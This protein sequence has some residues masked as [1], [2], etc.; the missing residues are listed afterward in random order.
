MKL[1]IV[2]PCYNEGL[3]LN[4][5]YSSLSSALKD[6]KIS[7]ELIMVDDGS[8][9]DTYK[10]LL[11]LNKL[12]KNVKVISFSKNFGKEQA[13]YAGLLDAT[14]NYTAIMD[15]DLQHTPTTLIEMYYKLI[16]N[17]DYD[18]VCAYRANRDDESTLKRTLTSL[19]YKLNNKISDVKLLPGAG[20]FRVFTKE[21]REA[22]ISFKEKTRFSKGIFSWIGFNTIYVPY[23][24]EKRTYG[25]SKWSIFKLIKYSLGGIISFSTVPVKSI[26]VL[27]SLLF[28]ISL[29]DFILMGHLSYRTIILFIGFVMFFI[30]IIALYISRIY[31]NLLDRPTFIIKHK[32]GFSAKKER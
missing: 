25:T 4:E 21:V 22:L 31:S 14:G 6:N 29:V 26:F 12:D 18:I 27:G 30:G 2:V 28:L 15:A 1:S 17:K 3:S 7:Y 19:F 13:M 23:T 8:T 24:P 10:K 32:V 9:D 20:D 5:F 11:D 16:D